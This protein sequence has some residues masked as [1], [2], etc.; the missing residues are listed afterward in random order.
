M[1]KPEVTKQHQW[2]KQLLGNW[3]YE[4]ECPGENGKPPQKMHGTETVRAV[5]DLW[6][7][8]EGEGEMPGGGEARM[9]L[10]L[11]YDP[12]GERFVG[13][14]IGSMMTELWVYDG[15]LDSSG[16]VLTLSADGPDFNDP[17][18]S[19]KYRD[20]IEMKSIDLRT[21][22]SNV[23]GPDGKWTPFMTAVYRRKL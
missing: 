17:A 23:L 14:W 6:V 19:G 5:G 22:T 18:K 1:M 12:K 4:H 8:G 2:L 21:L 7:I 20:V 3:T 10:T 16:K 11:G 9:I 13:T 15:E